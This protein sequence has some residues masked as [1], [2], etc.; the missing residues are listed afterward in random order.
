MKKSTTQMTKAEL[1]TVLKEK[2]EVIANLNA[3]VDELENLAIE[4]RAIPMDADGS[5]LLT[6]MNQKIK[7]LE[8]TV[9]DL[10]K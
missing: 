9:N 7:A 5:R 3:R 4:S 8:E 2:D 1:F 10:A 6:L